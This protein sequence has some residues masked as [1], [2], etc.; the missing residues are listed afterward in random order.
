MSMST[1]VV[2]PAQ[3]VSPPAA[4]VNTSRTSAAIL[5]SLAAILV[6]S[7]LLLAIF[8]TQLALAQQQQ[9]LPWPML[10]VVFLLGFVG[11]R[12]SLRIG[13]PPLWTG[14]GG[15][16]AR[17]ASP[18]LLGLA[19]GVLWVL[20]DLLKPAASAT[21]AAFPGIILLYTYAAIYVE[22]LLRLFFATF[23]VWLVAIVILRGR[24]LVPTYWTVAILL[25]LLQAS[26]QARATSQATG[27]NVASFE[28]I[29]SFGLAAIAEPVAF[30]LYRR[31]GFL[32]PLVFHFVIYV[33]WH[34]LG[35]GLVQQ[36]LL[37]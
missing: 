12:L 9:Y 33:I 19:V 30:Y 11:W 25:A 36:V 29:A 7:R 22:V 6:L 10:P 15:A 34:M 18:A 13:I 26:D 32:A 28:I 17:L 5:L 21:H 27:G 24:G 1:S 31:S 23:L 3:D 4:P 37:G 8:P 35:G 14:P 20:V 2:Q 16:R